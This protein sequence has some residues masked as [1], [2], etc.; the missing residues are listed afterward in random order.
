M[1]P[2]AQLVGFTLKNFKS[3]KEAV[4]PL[5]ALTLLVGTNAS[6]KSNCIEG[7][8]LLSW[9]ADGQPL[10]QAARSGG[11]AEIRG[12]V[13]EFFR[14][15]Q[16][17]IGFHCDLED[18]TRMGAHF[19]G[20]RDGLR[21]TGEHLLQGSQRLYR[22]IDRPNQFGRDIVIECAP[23]GEHVVCVDEQPVFTQLTTPARFGSSKAREL[24]PP[25]AIRVR[26]ALT[27]V[28]FLDPNPAVLRDYAFKATSE[29]GPDGEGLS[30]VLHGLC[31]SGARQTVLDFVR[32]LPEQN[33]SDI[34]F[35]DGAR[36]D[37]MLRLQETFGGTSSWHFATVLSDGTLRVLAVAA[38]LLS[39]P[40]GSLVVV[41]EL[42]NGV[43]PSRVGAL[44]ERIRN[45]A[46]R[47]KLRVLLTTHNPAMLDELPDRALPDVVVCFRHPDSGDS[48]LV[49][50]SDLDQ[51]VELVAAGRLG[52]L[53]TQGVLE[54]MIKDEQRRTPEERQAQKLEN[55]QRL[56]GS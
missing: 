41:E 16:Q 20:D 51:Y 7:L 15:Q 38:A 8:R 19:T 10:S 32:D 54:R 36:G 39:A 11:G 46:V 6:G 26:E 48:R 1:D 25:A 50:L 37:V 14:D 34:T 18:E 21:L 22:A 53:V 9:M 31:E 28:V 23:E 2:T 55:L 52:N 29:L 24:I 12:A 13:G 3:F 42:D 43:H 40:E 5:G 45:V 4:L 27:N 47:R 30:G 56:L 49:K 35:A 44:L 33:I 17:V